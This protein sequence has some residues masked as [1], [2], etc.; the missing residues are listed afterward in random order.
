MGVGIQALSDELLLDAGV[1]EVLHL[2]VGPPG[3]VLR[4]LGPPVAQNPVNVDDGPLLQ[5]GEGAPLEV[6]P[7][8]VY[9]SQP[10]AL[11]APLQSCTY[12]SHIK[13]IL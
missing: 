8:V 13:I 10:A 6:R 1:P 2:V 9:P 4:Y 5:L 7:Q 12:Y 11:P 3:Q